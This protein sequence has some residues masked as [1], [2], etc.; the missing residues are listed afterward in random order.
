M[1]TE[2]RINLNGDVKL[3]VIAET[4]AEFRLLNHAWTLNEFERGN[5]QSTAPGGGGVG[6]YIPLCRMVG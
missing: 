3:E 2:L 6:F 5:G 4:D 1:K